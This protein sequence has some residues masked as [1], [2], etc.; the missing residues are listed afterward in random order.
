MSFGIGKMC[1]EK[2]LIRIATCIRI[3]HALYFSS[4]MQG[5]LWLVV[6]AANQNLAAWSL[7]GCNYS[8]VTLG[9]VEQAR[10]HLECTKGRHQGSKLVKRC[11]CKREGLHTSKNVF[12]N[13]KLILVRSKYFLLCET[14]I[15]STKLRLR[16]WKMHFCALKT[17]S[18]ACRIVAEI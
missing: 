12:L 3:M 2:N 10:G 11:M 16:A 15:S 1:L 9:C 5:M 17:W 8:I 6:K 14:N 13:T 7:I 4:V 18:F